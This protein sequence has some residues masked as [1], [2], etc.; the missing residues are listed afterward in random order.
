PRG[1]IGSIIRKF[2]TYG[3]SKYSH[4][5]G[6][7]IQDDLMKGFTTTPNRAAITHSELEHNN[8]LKQ[9]W[10]GADPDTPGRIPKCTPLLTTKNIKGQLEYGW[11][12]LDRF[13]ETWYVRR[14]KDQA[15]DQK[16][17]IP[18][19]K[20]G[21]GLMMMWG[22]F[23]VTGNGHLDHQNKHMQSPQNFTMHTLELLSSPI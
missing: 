19:V 23:S 3:T 6:K 9:G 16:N 4:G 8:P 18:T 5:T 11:R 20:H 10:M 21:G 12:N 22:C 13:A 7:H 14:E 15:Y 17:T 1:T 2:K